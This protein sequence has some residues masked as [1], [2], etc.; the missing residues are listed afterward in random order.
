[1]R[2]PTPR[3]KAVQAAFDRFHSSTSPK[4]EADRQL[5]AD[6]K[7]VGGPSAYRDPRKADKS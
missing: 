4:P 2:T 3:D 6:M 7:R 1:M 5:R